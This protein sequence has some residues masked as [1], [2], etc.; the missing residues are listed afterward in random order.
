MA[1]SESMRSLSTTMKSLPSP[2]YLVKR[3]WVTGAL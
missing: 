2:W 1:R 3:S